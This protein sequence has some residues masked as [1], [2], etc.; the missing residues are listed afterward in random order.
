MDMAAVETGDEVA[1]QLGGAAS[2]D[3]AE[4]LSLGGREDVVAEVGGTVAV[5]DV[6]HGRAS[7]RRG[8]R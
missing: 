8:S 4:D 3:G 6:R 7:L 5:E 2:D 1:A